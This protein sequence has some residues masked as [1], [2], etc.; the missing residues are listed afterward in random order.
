MTSHAEGDQ[1]VTGLLLRA[2]LRSGQVVA[3]NAGHPP[4]YLLRNGQVECLELA[5]D[6][7]FGM[8]PGSTYRGQEL[9]L[10]AGDRLVVVTDGLL[11]RN[12]IAAHFD[13][14]AAVSET[15]DLHP[16]VVH[17]FKT[18]VLAATGELADDAAT[19]CIDWHGSSGLASTEM[20]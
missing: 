2:D 10:Q 13:V 3:V 7:P 5:P 18:A 20:H 8:I 17:A 12:P 9:Q 1:F 16:R 14:L 6:I 4:P 11:E 19:V 15:A